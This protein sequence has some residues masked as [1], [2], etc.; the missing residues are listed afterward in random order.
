MILPALRGLPIVSTLVLAVVLLTTGLG[1]TRP[2]LVH[3]VGVVSVLSWLPVALGLQTVPVWAR[4][5]LDGLTA[6][7]LDCCRWVLCGVMALIW[8]AVY[9]GKHAGFELG[10]YDVGIYS[11]VA[12]NSSIG[13]WFFSSVQQKN[14]LGEHLSPVMA[15]FAPL[16]RLQ[17]DLR[18]LLLAQLA[19][20]CLTPWPLDRLV[21]SLG[22]ARRPAAV[23]SCGLTLLW[24][25][26]P[27]MQAAMK[28]PFHTSSLAA[29]LILF[30]LLWWRQQRFTRFWAGISARL[31]VKEN[32]PLVLAGQ[33]TATLAQNRHVRRG[34]LLLLLS[35]CLLWLSTQWLIPWIEGG[36]Y[37]K[38][39]R[40]APFALLP[41]KVQYLWGL[42]SPLGYLP[43]LHWRH[44]IVAFPAVMQ[45][46][47]SGYQPML[48]L[49]FHYDDITAPL[50][51]SALPSPLLFWWWPRLAQRRRVPSMAA[52]VVLMVALVSVP[53]SPLLSLIKDPPLAVHYQLH[54]RL[55]ELEAHVPRD[56]WILS[57]HALGPY[58]HHPLHRPFTSDADRCS[59][60]GLPAG[61]V[62]VLSDAVNDAGIRDLPLCLAEL[63]QEKTA[64]W[65][66][67]YQPLQVFRLRQQ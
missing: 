65:L 23:C 59:V 62:I 25:I 44:G 17:P 47:A 56:A 13:A 60:R 33:G 58:L 61:S 31:L 14:H 64:E 50:L 63:Q 43:L 26:Y 3:E 4:S 10:N 46:L 29:P 7:R 16:Y 32:L 9:W 41:D 8:G 49:R 67:Q 66:V 37:S 55:E 1:L 24:F 51:F 6:R 21:R 42:L 53:K 35:V 19:A 12:Y 52:A 48:S 30:C 54:R 40:L 28:T 38:L 18:W 20:Y 34:L 27:P 11:S 5:I 39:S 36:D 22:A 45:N 15:L 2:Q 57:Q